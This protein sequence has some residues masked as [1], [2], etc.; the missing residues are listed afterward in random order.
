MYLKCQK[1][2]KILKRGKSTQHSWIVKPLQWDSKCTTVPTD[3]HTTHFNP[4]QLQPALSPV[5][6]ST[7]QEQSRPPS[8]S[9]QQCKPK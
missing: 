6:S 8:Q 4:S 7:D 1:E 9:N 2:I 3:Q 5:P